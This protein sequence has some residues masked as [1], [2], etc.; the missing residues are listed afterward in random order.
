MQYTILP[1]TN[2]H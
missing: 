1:S 2:D